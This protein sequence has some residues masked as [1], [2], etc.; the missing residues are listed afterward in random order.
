MPRL[1]PIDGAAKG[2]GKTLRAALSLSVATGQGFEMTRIRAGRLQPG[3]RPDHLAA[4]RAVALTCHARVG[5][6]FEGSPDL[7]FEPGPVA[8]AA[9]EF[10]L[11]AAGPTT[12]VLQAVAPV[13]ATA[14]EPSRVT[15]SGGT[16]VPDSPSFH[17]VARH[18]VPLVERL[19]LAVVPRLVSAGFHPK[20]GG[21]LDAEIRP[22]TRPAALQLVERG[23][24]RALRGVSGIPP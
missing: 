16:H 17:Y 20:G 12:L 19:G 10:D 11:G 3:L 5:G 15:L 23:P 24:R 18:W 1:I 22:W 8:P 9:F 7:R 13:L 14:P 4:V 6:A 2:A 21:T